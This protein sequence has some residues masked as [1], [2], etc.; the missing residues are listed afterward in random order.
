MILISVDTLRAD[1]LGAY[2][3]ERDTSPALDQLAS[4]SVRF[5]NAIA[6]A[7]WTLPSHMTLMTSLRP[8]VH[9]VSTRTALAPQALTLAEALKTAGYRTAGFVSWVYVSADFGFDQGF[10][11]F[12]L[13][14]T[15]DRIDMAGGGGAYLAGRSV[16]IAG[17]WLDEQAT[18][19]PL[20]LF[21]HLF[22]PHT[23]YVPPGQY[24]EMFDP[25][26]S[27]SINGRYDTLEHFNPY[28]SDSSRTIEPRD[29]EHVTALYDGEIRYVDDQL[30][31]FFA[32]LDE[33][34]G[35]D[36]CLIVFVSDHGEEFMD[37]GSMEGHGWTLYEE[38]IRVPMMMR[39]PGG[40]GAGEVV[41]SPVAL[42]DVAPTILDWIGEPRPE[43]FEG[44]SLEPLLLGEAEIREPSYVISENNRW[45]TIRWA[46]RGERYK[47]IVTDHTGINSAGVR[48]TPGN[49]LYDLQ[50]DPHEQVNLFDETDPR[51]QSL[52]AL[53]E[54]LRAAPG[55][56]LQNPEAELSPEQLELLRSLGYVQ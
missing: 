49:E 38:I 25:E 40:V 56:R 13:L 20:F 15:M 31:R 30:E 27:G 44:V 52:L 53:L 12:Q 19:D 10:D 23:D 42:M 16:D 28:L 35:L 48:I 32:K 24:I 41:D 11:H 50:A 43:Q 21:L 45:N 3:Y 14:V 46:I 17:E 5:S 9:G 39:L 51:S 26:Y 34:L 2:G 7:G 4:E 8:S 6:Q 22:D 18:E 33:R 55:E 1:H 54:R 29:L 37:H 36:N 47:L